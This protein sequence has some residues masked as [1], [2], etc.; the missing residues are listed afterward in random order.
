[1]ILDPSLLLLK[2]KI[3]VSAISSDMSKCHKKCHVKFKKFVMPKNFLATVDM[4]SVAGLH[5]FI[6]AILRYS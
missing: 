1:M 6:Y 3:F 4:I 5:C 2:I